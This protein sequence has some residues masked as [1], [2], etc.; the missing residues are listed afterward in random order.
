MARGIR[1]LGSARDPP[2]ESPARRLH[3][4][5]ARPNTH[6]PTPRCRGS[7]TTQCGASS[8]PE[9]RSFASTDQP[10]H[11]GPRHRSRAPNRAT[12]TAPAQ[13]HQSTACGGADA[14]GQ[15]SGTQPLRP[16]PPGSGR[17]TGLPRGSRRAG[18]LGNRLGRQRQVDQ[19]LGQG[20]PVLAQLGHRR[21]KPN[22]HNLEP[23]VCY[24]RLHATSGAGTGAT[25][26]AAQ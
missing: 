26:A 15:P 5:A 25:G 18:Q 14:T 2:G 4:G 1:S 17:M 21:T 8:T 12:R 19:Q 23:H 10:D 7:R 22:T 16:T 13:Q 24:S 3:G 9:T 6:A 11:Q 20:E